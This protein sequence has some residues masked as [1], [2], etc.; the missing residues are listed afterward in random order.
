MPVKATKA[1]PKAPAKRAAVPARGRR[2]PLLRAS[3]VRTILQDLTATVAPGDVADLLELEAMLR[4]RAAKLKAPQ[5]ALLRTQ[6]DFAL[7]VLRDHQDGAC[8]QIPYS[9]ISLLTAGVCYFADEMDVIPDF[10]P[11][12]GRLDDAVVMAMAFEMAE[13]GIRRY[14]TWKERPTAPLFGVR[15]GRQERRPGRA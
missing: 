4:E 8:P 1:A 14:C 15:G 9:T 2:V 6:L 10:L 5:L 13:D 7:A 12:V 11:G 3:D